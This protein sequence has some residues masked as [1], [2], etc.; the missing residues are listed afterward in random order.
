MCF[1]LKKKER[2]KE[3]GR[4]G[5]EYALEMDARMICVALPPVCQAH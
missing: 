2:K 4:A 1:F 5:E 3:K